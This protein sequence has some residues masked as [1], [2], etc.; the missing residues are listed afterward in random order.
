MPFA[1]DFVW[2]AAAASYQIEGAYQ[3]DGRGLSVWDVFS[4][5]PDKV[6]YGHT[7][8]VACDH[9]NRYKEDINL[10]KEIGLKAYRLS[11]AWPRILPMGTGEVNA[12]G[13][14]FYDR[15]VDGLLAADIQPYVTLFH[16]DLPYELYLRGSWMNRES[17]DWFADYVTA[18][19]ERLGDRVTHWITLNE[20]A[21]F[22]NMGYRYGTH[23]PGDRLSDRHMTRMVHNIL[24]AHGKAVEA[25]RAASA[26]PCD[27]GIAPDTGAFMPGHDDPAYVERVKDYYFEFKAPD[28]FWNLAMWMDPIVLG[29]Y[30]A[31]A[32]QMWDEAG[33]LPDIRDGDMAQINQAIDFI[34][35][36]QYRG[37]WI[38]EVN[39]ELGFRPVSVD[40]PHTRFDWVIHPEILYWGP[41]YIHE[42]YQKPIYITENGLSS[43][44]WVSMD[45]KVHDYGRID[46]TRRHLLQLERAIDDGVPV[47]GYFHWSI[48]DN[49]EWARGYRERFGMIYVN[50]DTQ[51][52][53]PKQSAYWYKDVITSN[54]AR[55]HED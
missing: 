38:D 16:W 13:L 40:H 12:A 10:M 30:P 28:D 54:G 15:L 21:V 37:W 31:E 5:T 29:D 43:M 14:D 50:Y 24:R 19:V 33:I 6:D 46:F 7:G 35:V 49:F 4:H 26:G 2:A 44:D 32:L 42:R 23:A 1:D 55:L 8:D 34:G 53:T 48:M 52:R 36:N 22:T 9:Y 45:G 39:G 41:R 17:A 3:T 25:I 51:E 18:V 20:P 27:V 47:K 11:I